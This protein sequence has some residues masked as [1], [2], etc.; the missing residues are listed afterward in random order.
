MRERM[1]KDGL[2]DA[3]RMRPGQVRNSSTAVRFALIPITP[4]H[5]NSLRTPALCRTEGGKMKNLIPTPLD[6]AR[7][8][9]GAILD[10]YGKRY[11]VEACLSG[12]RLEVADENGNL[13]WLSRFQAA[14][15][16]LIAA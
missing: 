13:Y 15:A 4:R 9:P 11:T 5:D 1:A 12:G 6:V 10:Y 14:Y 7:I 16:K 2:G 3:Y 8:R